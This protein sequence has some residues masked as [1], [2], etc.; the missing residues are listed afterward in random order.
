VIQEIVTPAQTVKQMAGSEVYIGLIV[1]VT[2][3][4][5]TDRSVHELTSRVEVLPVAFYLVNKRSLGDRNA[6]L[7]LFA[8]FLSRR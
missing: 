2:P 4:V 7:I 5:I 3:R 8:S 6:H 1:Y